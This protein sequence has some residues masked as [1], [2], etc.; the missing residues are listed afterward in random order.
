M[1]EYKEF[2]REYETVLQV[3]LR[4]AK[5]PIVDGPLIEHITIG[6]FLSR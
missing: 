3:D 4:F 6:E 2:G 1:H 5:W